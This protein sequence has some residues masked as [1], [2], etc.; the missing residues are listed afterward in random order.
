MQARYREL[1][2]DRGELSRLLRRGAEKAGAVAAATL[3]RAHTA[4]GLLPR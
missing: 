1:I 4:I 3:Q 2:D